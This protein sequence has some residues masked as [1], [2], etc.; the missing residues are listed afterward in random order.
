MY[1]RVV[2]GIVAEIVQGMYAGGVLWFFAGV[3]AVR[4]VGAWVV[5]GARKCW[6][7]MLG[8]CWGLMLL[9]PNWA[10]CCGMCA[11]LRSWAV[12]GLFAGTRISFVAYL[13]RVGDVAGT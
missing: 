12:L 3:M 4:G 2:L 11:L 8:S 10:C 6:G 7:C 9:R 13:G 1:A 5:V